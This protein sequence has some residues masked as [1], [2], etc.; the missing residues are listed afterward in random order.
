VIRKHLTPA[1]TG[2]SIRL[3]YRASTALIALLSIGTPITIAGT[4]DHPNPAVVRSALQRSSGSSRALGTGQAQ[5]DQAGADAQ[6]KAAAQKPSPLVD[7]EMRGSG[8]ET[9]DNPGTCGGATCDATNGNCE[10]LTFK[11]T[12]NATQVGNAPWTASLTVNLDDCT[13]TGTPGGFCCTGDGLLSATTGTGG[14]ANT[15]GMSLTGPVCVDPNAA[16]DVNIQG[17]FI[18]L[19]AQSSGKFKNSTGT[20]QL[21]AYMAAADGTTYISGRGVLQVVS[22]F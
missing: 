12:L 14:S 19:P 15:L 17:G 3:I 11:G 13:N 20:G 2:R 8:T 16:L 9:G 5:F 22:P 10:C 1:N 21:D 7:F 18:I 4:S 6:S